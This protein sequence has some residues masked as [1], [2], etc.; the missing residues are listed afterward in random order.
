MMGSDMR[1]GIIGE[2]ENGS[3]SRKT[4][5]SI[6]KVS[7]LNNALNL[8]ID[9]I[10]LDASEERLDSLPCDTVFVYD[11]IRGNDTV[12]RY[13]KAIEHYYSHCSP[14]MIIVCTRNDVELIV[15]KAATQLSSSGFLQCDAIEFDESMDKFIISKS[16]Y[17]GNA[18]AH[19]SI[20]KTAILSFNHNQKIKEKLNAKNTSIKN[21]DYKC[22]CN[23]D[24]IANKEIDYIEEQGLEKSEFV[25]V[26][27][28]GIGNKAAVEEICRWAET[29]G[30]AVGGTKKVV[31]H[32]WL[33]IHQL[34][35]QTGLMIA[36][37]ICLVLGASGATPFING[38]I[39][40]EKIIAVNSD[41][42]A[43]IFDYAD[44]AVVE[45]CAVI[46]AGLLEKLNNFIKK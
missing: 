5:D 4:Y 25:I 2:F 11:Q 24:F 45:D 38:I 21:I 9:L 22:S 20:E 10:V 37:K 7:Q 41:L 12:G 36:P 40:S 3:L 46:T 44:I 31:D 35:G 8:V 23:N 14:S 18:Q 15:P 34:I 6:F 30:A 43:R 1:I 39:G 27:G 29:V 28:R 19:Y 26:C 33:S 16:V 42:N 32:G 13:I 17:G